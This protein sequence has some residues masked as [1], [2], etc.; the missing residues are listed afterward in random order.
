ML[1][2]KWTNTK[3]IM[4]IDQMTSL[5]P[6]NLILVGVHELRMTA[7]RVLYRLG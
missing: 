7:G 5:D 4:T 3:M 2:I 1:Q 6:F